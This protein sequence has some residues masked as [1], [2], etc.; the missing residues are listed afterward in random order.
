MCGT[1]VATGESRRTAKSTKPLAPERNKEP[2]SNWTRRRHGNPYHRFYEKNG[3]AVL[4]PFEGRRNKKADRRA[5]EKCVATG[6][7][8]QTRRFAVFPAGNLQICVP[9]GV[10]IP[11]SFG[12]PDENRLFSA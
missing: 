1:F 5:A 7:V 3:R 4:L 2:Y 6:G 8:R 11:A 9:A 10:H 12:I